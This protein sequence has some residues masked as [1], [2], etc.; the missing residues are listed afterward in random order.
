MDGIM[1]VVYLYLLYIINIM[2]EA[3]RSGKKSKK[4]KMENEKKRG[5]KKL[6]LNTETGDYIFPFQ[7]L[8]FPFQ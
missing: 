2:Y 8:L 6:K 3:C 7:S 4:R 1:G 5:L